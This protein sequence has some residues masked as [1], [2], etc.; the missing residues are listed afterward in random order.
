[1]TVCL[2]ETL[3]TIQFECITLKLYN[4]A[5]GC[6]SGSW[7]LLVQ[8]IHKWLILP[9]YKYV[10]GNVLFLSKTRGNPPVTPACLPNS[11]CGLVPF[12][13]TLEIKTIGHKRIISSIK[14]MA[15]FYKE[16][17]VINLVTSLH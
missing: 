10:G 11:A 6:L 2:T 4:S 16:Y 1:M 17:L 7:T 5:P 3:F 8:I 13:E 15:T 9:F 12:P 14:L